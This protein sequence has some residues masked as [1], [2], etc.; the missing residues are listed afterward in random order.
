MNARNFEHQPYT[1]QKAKITYEVYFSTNP[2]SK[3]KIKK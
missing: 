1:K 3:D 2:T